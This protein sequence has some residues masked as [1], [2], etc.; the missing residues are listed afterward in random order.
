M[1]KQHLK[2]VQDASA[3]QKT[4]A[5]LK[6]TKRARAPLRAGPAVARIFNLGKIRRRP[7]RSPASLLMA[8]KSETSINALDESA[9]AM[10]MAGVAGHDT[11]QYLLPDVP[12]VGSDF[13]DN[14]GNGAI[15]PR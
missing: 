11:D 6:P 5:T 7:L 1:V 8:S 2:H 10:G 15:T 4:H 13:E 12:A 9:M 3:R 14:R